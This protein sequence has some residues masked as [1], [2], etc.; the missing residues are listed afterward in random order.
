MAESASFDFDEGVGVAGD[1]VGEVC[2]GEVGVGAGLVE[3]EGFHG[4]AGQGMGLAI[5]SLKKQLESIGDS[6]RI[7]FGIVS[8]GQVWGGKCLGRQC[9][10]FGP[11]QAWIRV[12]LNCF[13][14]FRWLAAFC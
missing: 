2:W 8:V 11:M 3:E 12:I 1:W 9:G 13:C 10:E 6:E 4:V 14:F 7:V 5:E